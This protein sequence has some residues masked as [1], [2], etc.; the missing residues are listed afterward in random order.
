MRITTS[1]APPTGV[2]RAHALAAG[3][4]TFVVVVLALGAY[5]VVADDACL[6][7]AHHPVD[8]SQWSGSQR[9]ASW[10]PAAVRCSWTGPSGSHVAWTITAWP[11]WIVYGAIVLAALVAASAWIGAAWSRRS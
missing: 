5:G 3:A 9:L 11:L 8:P 7:D 6:T 2:V 4:L 10:P 1:R